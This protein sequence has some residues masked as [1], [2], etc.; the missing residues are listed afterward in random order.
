MPHV[1]VAA[2][3]AAAITAL[4]LPLSGAALPQA[5]P[6]NTSPP[7]TS[8]TATKG[9]TLVAAT[10]SWTGTAPISF[11]FQWLRCDSAGANCTSI[12]GAT[13]TTY[14]L[15]S[16]D[17]GARLRVLV[18]ASNADGTASALSDATAVVTSGGV[19]TPTG[20]PVIS[21]SPVAGQRLSA[22]NGSWTGDQ[23]MTFAYQWV[24]CGADGGNPDG[25]NCTTISGA[26]GTTY[27]LTSAEVGSRMRVRVT[28]MN[29]SGSQTAASNPTGT[30]KANAPV[31][32]KGPTVSGSMVE[33]QTATVNPGTWSGAA[34][35][36]FTYQ[37]I[38]CTQG[39]SCVSIAGA[40]G[41]QYKLTA[42]DVGRRLKARVTA[43][44]SGGS[45]TVLSGETPVIIAAGPAGVITLPGGE[46]SIPV[47]S[48]PKTER[49]VVERVIFTPS[50]VRSIQ[51]TLSIQVRV[52]DTRGYVV[53]DAMVFIRSTPLVTQAGQPRRPTLTNG[54]AVFQ[55]TANRSFP[56][57]RRGAVQFFVKTYKAGDNPLAGVAGYRLVQVRIAR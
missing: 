48:V 20:E 23:P 19:P 8:G 34:P 57:A 43:R 46:K 54:Y 7:T 56:S 28:A 44:N 50:V 39:A 2:L 27:V 31:N 5:A 9:Q 42:S 13:N 55:M 51:T 1:S 21:G 15:Q 3:V 25:S 49:L 41:V 12:A 24:R 22:T 4:L 35:I 52:K 32:S 47:T 26:T 18:T 30:V 29:S 40:T 14:V 33:G 10:G 38:R 45:T 37:W 36:T 53:R 16:A 11:A 6:V 17:V